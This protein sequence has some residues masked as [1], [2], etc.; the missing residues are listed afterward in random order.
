LRFFIR[1]LRIFQLIKSE[2][3][4]RFLAMVYNHKG[5]ICQDQCPL[6]QQ[7]R[8]TSHVRSLQ[9]H[10][11]GQWLAGSFSFGSVV[12]VVFQITFCV[13]IYA[14]DVFLFFKNHF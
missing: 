7:P 1:G 14:N 6:K 9:Y 11:G 10:L 8:R 13:E 4:D 2:E 3:A 12:M 5:G